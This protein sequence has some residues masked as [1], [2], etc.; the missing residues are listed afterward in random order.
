MTAKDKKAIQ[1]LQK[2]LD[3]LKDRID[4]VSSELAALQGGEENVSGNLGVER[5]AAVNE[6]VPHPKFSEGEV[7]IADE[8]TEEA[9]ELADIIEK[10][11]EEKK[12]RKKKKKKKK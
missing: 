10:E 12:A 7:E 6:A 8:L 11:K 3:K 5:K 4:Q 2:K 1:K 9:E